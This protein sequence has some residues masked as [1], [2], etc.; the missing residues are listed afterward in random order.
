M[1]EMLALFSSL[2]D[3]VIYPVQAQHQVNVYD[4]MGNTQARL[5]TS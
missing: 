4:S 3:G 1:V 2:G 5:E